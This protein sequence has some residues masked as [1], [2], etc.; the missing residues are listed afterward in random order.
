MPETSRIHRKKPLSMEE[1][2]ELFIK[3]LR[4]AAGLNTQCVFRAWD[5]ASGAER[6]TVRRF[7]RGGKLY[8]TLN[9]SALR[10][11]LFLQRAAL[12]DKINILL[13]QD[14]L[15]TTDDPKVPFVKEII[16]K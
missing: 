3:D 13:R 9:S 10:S 12:T 6:Y 15:F 1:V 16:L 14:P 2:V 7:F 4:L 8:I 5:K 11:M